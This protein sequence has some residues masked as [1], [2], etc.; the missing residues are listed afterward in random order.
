MKLFAQPLSQAKAPVPG[1]PE[2]DRLSGHA[3][4]ENRML[5][6]AKVLWDAVN[7]F[8]NNDGAAMAG[9]IAFTGLLSIFPFLIF[10]TT[11]IGIMVGPARTDEIIS[12][13]FQIAPS[14][15]AMTLEPVVDEVLNK[16]SGS[17]L[18]LSAVF[19][20]WVASNAIE[21]L[22]TALDRAYRVIDRRGLIAGRLI[23]VG[24]VFAGVLVSALLGF[25]VL[26]SPLIIRLIQSAGV[27]IPGFAPFISYAF[28]LLVF[29]G[30]LMMTHRYLPGERLKTKR[31]WRGVVVTTVL[32]MASAAAFS[33]YLNFAPSYTVTYGA[34]AGVII[35]LLFF[36]I[37]GAAII[38]G[39]EVNAAI[40]GSG[41]LADRARTDV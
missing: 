23:A 17:V 11:L 39:A 19:A 35:T 38:F 37:T 40:N 24:F 29:F 4:K 12:A 22:R 3:P 30:F 34:L 25:S 8:N 7:R 21:A 36:Y 15:V 26:L 10:A 9:F 14:H 5:R 2:L 28:G 27:R 18:T 32:W 20:I 1:H 16:R 13:L 6:S 31:L 41:R 33:A